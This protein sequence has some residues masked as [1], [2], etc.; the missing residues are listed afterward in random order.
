MTIDLHSLTGK[1]PII[2]KRGFVLPNFCGPFNPLEKQLV[3]D[4]K[5]NILKYIQQPTVETDKICSKHDDKY[6]LSR[7]LEDKHQADK[8]MIDSIN[9]LPYKDKQWGTFLVKNVISSKKKLG[10]GNNPN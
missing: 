5:G 9:K 3:Y 8:E 10:L 6:T 1:L 2:P 4:Q 7:S